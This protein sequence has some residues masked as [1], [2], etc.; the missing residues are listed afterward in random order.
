MTVEERFMSK[1]LVDEKTNC[2]NWNGTLRDGYGR[3]KA[4]KKIMNASRFSFEYYNE[5]IL[6]GN[7][8]MHICDN[9]KCVNPEHLKQGTHKDNAADKVSKNRHVYGEKAWQHKLTEKQVIEIKQ[10]LKNP[11]IGINNDLANFYSVN[12]RTISDIKLGK[13]WSHISTT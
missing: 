12:H 1:V 9:P 11:Y 6:D 13:R 10:K 5:K 2:W 7:V 8:I 4:N 3:F